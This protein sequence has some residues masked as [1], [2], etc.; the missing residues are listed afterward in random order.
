MADDREQLY[1]AL[2]NA[3]AAGDTK[4]AQR[5]AEYI[6]SLPSGVPNTEIDPSVPRVDVA[7]HLVRDPQ[8]A[9]QTA[10]AD[11]SLVDRIIGG[12]ETALAL[13]TGATT[14]LV[15][16][17]GGALA[18]IGK[19]IA[20]G[21]F[22]TQQGVSTVEQAAGEGMGKFTYAPRTPEGQKQTEAWGNLLHLAEPVM[23]LTAEMSAL[24]KG[25]TTAAE[26]ARDLT[27]VARGA[28][29]KTAERIAASNAA[30]NASDAEL[31]AQQAAKLRDLV[32]KPQSTLSGVGS[33]AASKDAVKME[34]FERLGIKPTLG[35]LTRDKDQL[36]FEREIAKTNEGKAVDTHLAE[37]NAQ[38]NRKF[39]ELADAYGPNA[40]D[41]RE[42]GSSV[43]DALEA[44]KAE[45]KAEIKAAY[46]EADAAGEMAAPVD[47]TN[48]VTFVKANKGK[49]KVAPIISM[50]ESEL[51][52]N[53]TPIGGNLDKLT[54]TPTS[55]R[56][57]MSLRGSE[58][59]RQAINDAMEPGTPNSVWGKKAIRLIDKATEDK[60][61]PLYQQARRLYENYSKEFT[62]RDVVS[63]LLRFKPG[64]RDRAV[65]PESVFQH[66]ILN[67]KGKDDISHIFRVLEAHSANAD[68]A[69]VAAGRQAA[70]NLR[71][72]LVNHI[73]DK[74][75]SNGGANTFGEV[76]GSQK[77]ILDAVNGLDA[78]GKLRAVLGRDGAEF[79]R[80]LRDAAVDLYTLPEGVSQ[81]S[82]NAGRIITA[83]ESLEKRTKRIPVAEQVTGYVG[84]RARERVIAKRIEKAL[85]PKPAINNTPF[86]SPQKRPAGAPVH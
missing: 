28:V 64:T 69:V 36:S 32:R 51:G 77:K 23:P 11:P 16:A 33:A 86:N 44:K 57:T 19:S 15:G 26:G 45:K 27:P 29:A 2:R 24:G 81:P 58:D 38:V 71:G 82:N 22:G 21:T 66:V 17:A 49:D 63:K 37:Q 48:L 65:V 84:D 4:A 39:E 42:V 68:P 3:D 1:E 20:D 12:G 74:M 78:R 54:L 14:G 62:D 7:G 85:N 13:A 61:G 55:K 50:L 5:L 60:G 53:S 72:A 34:R 76:V 8:P 18:G 30:V 73:R 31:A 70:A 46:D 79:V 41:L 6:Q 35:Q 25:V 47:V 10:H 67:P 75:F 56:F 40:S 80:D 9:A 83:I 52:Q 43:L 59:L